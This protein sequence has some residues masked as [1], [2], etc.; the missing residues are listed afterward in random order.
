MKLPINQQIK[1]SELTAVEPII[2]ESNKDSKGFIHVICPSEGITTEKKY[3]TVNQINTEQQNQYP[4]IYYPKKRTLIKLPRKAP[5][6][7]S[8]TVANKFH[9][10]L[11]N[12]LANDYAIYDDLIL[13][14]QREAPPYIPDFVLIKESD[15]QTIFIALE[16]DEPY[17]HQSRTPLHCINQDKHRN[18]YFT[19]RGWVVI[20]FAEI[21]VHQFPEASCDQLGKLIQKIDPDFHPPSFPKKQQ[22]LQPVNCWTSLQAKKWASNQQREKY[23]KGKITAPTGDFFYKYTIHETFIDQII[24][25]KIVEPV[26]TSNHLTHLASLHPHVRDERITFDSEKHA[27]TIDGH[28]DVISVSEIIGKFFPEFDSEY[29]S[30]KKAKQRGVAVETILKEWKEKGETASKLGTYL[31]EQIENFYNKKPHD[32]GTIEFKYFMDF[33][34]KYPQM[35]EHRTEWRVF[36]EELMIAG[37]IDMIYRNPKTDDYFMFDWKRSEKVVDGLSQPIKPAFQF[38]CGELSHLSDNSYNKYALQQNMYKY[39]VEKRYGKK[40]SSMNL[41]VLH[42]NRHSYHIVQLPNMDQ[43]INYITSVLRKRK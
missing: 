18:D 17:D 34:K 26:K 37:T 16:I 27:Y 6:I 11:V 32:S 29:W 15:T 2:D 28:P 22:D 13:A 14:T 9:S 10:H 38:A 42:P 43:E 21:Q 41:L 8:G 12:L 23:L 36:D 20:R 19:Q 5:S 1:T 31:H 40:I 39:L 33:V 7:Q 30:K 35:E 25:A 24:R 4:I 3:T